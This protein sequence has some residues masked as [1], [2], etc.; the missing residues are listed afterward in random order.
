M[1]LF[2]AHEPER[3]PTGVFGVDAQAAP[4]WL[5]QEALAESRGRVPILYVEAVPVRVD[6]LGQVE[7]LGVLLR[8]SVD[9]RMT[10]SLVSGRVLLGESVR[11]ALL[12]NLEKD[13]GP[14]AFPQLPA[15]PV[16]FTVAE[17][18][19]LPGVTPL[20]DPRQHA[21]A[22]VYVV[23]VTG[24]CQPRQDALELTWLT[25]EEALEPEVLADMEG[26]RGLLVKQALAHLG[27]L[28]A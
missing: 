14:A 27:A 17:Y 8:G 12:R 9:G 19:P 28:P 16:P 1:T 24:D 23:P 6:H 5:S 2:G 13:L 3:E 10:R 4:G 11:R 22:L 21:V 26:G 25:P 15:N 18:L 20:H 7:R